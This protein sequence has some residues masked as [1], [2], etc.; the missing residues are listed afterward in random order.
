MIKTGFE[1][2]V[3]APNLVAYSFAI[4]ATE[5]FSMRMLR[6]SQKNLLMIS[7]KENMA[8]TENALTKTLKLQLMDAKIV[9]FAKPAFHI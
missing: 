5:G 3:M 7:I 9:I 6:L 8:F 2:S 1:S 4:V